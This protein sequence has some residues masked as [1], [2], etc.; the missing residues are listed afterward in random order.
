MT[1]NKFNGMLPYLVSSSLYV[2]SQ[3]K[4][5]ILCHRQIPAEERGEA[6]HTVIGRKGGNVE[7]F[8]KEREAMYGSFGRRGHVYKLREDM[9]ESSCVSSY[10]VSGL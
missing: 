1:L 2:G 7:S 5:F 10:L 8:R 6:G 9:G 4:S 3:I